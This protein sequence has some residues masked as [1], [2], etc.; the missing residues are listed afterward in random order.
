MRCCKKR[1]INVEMHRVVR[2]TGKSGGVG[3]GKQ[4]VTG[5]RRKGNSAQ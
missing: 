2:K 3:A 5:K 1:G 4:R